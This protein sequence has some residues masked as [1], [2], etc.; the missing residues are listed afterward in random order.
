MPGTM[1]AHHGH[2]VRDAYGVLINHA[3]LLAWRSA[4]EDSDKLGHTRVTLDQ[5]LQQFSTPEVLSRDNKWYCNQCKEHVQA[6]KSLQ[7]WKLPE[8]LILHLKRFE[9]RN[10]LYPVKLNQNVAFPLQG[11]DLNTHERAQHVVGDDGTPSPQAELGGAVYDLFGVVNH[12]GSMGFGHCT[13]G[14]VH[15]NTGPPERRS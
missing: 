1:A 4:S 14:S 3:R 12:I 10:I 9:Y 15:A 8:V 2:C 6:T 7:I 5:C 11:L 13:C